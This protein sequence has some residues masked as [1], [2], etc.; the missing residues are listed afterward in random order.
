MSFDSREAGVAELTPQ[1]LLL[2]AVDALPTDEREQVLVWLLER[3]FAGTHLP[4]ATTALR[5]EL[6][7]PAEA[8]LNRELGEHRVVPIQLPSEQHAALRDWCGEHGFTMVTVVRGLVERFL[9]ERGQRPARA[10]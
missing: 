6:V 3:S 1:E 7:G 9:E 2:R 5:P 4:G 10:A 8:L